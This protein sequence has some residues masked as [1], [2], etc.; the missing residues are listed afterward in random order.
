MNGFFN[1]YLVIDLDSQTWERQPLSDSDL[2]RTLGGKGLGLSLL[3]TYTRGVPNPLSEDNPVVLAV[4][5]ASDSKI[6]GS[7]RWVVLTRSPLTGFLAHSYSG[8]RQSTPMS[9]TGFDAFVIRGASEKPVWLEISTEGVTFHDAT[10]LWG[11]DTYDTQK[12]LH[13]RIGARVGAMVIGPAA[14][15]GVRFANIANDKWRHAGRGGAGAVL[16]AKKVKGITFKGNATRPHAE[17]AEILNYWK[18]MISVCKGNEAVGNYKRMGTPMMVAVMNNAEAFPARYWHDGAMD[19]WEDISADYLLSHLKVTVKACEQCFVA[20]AKVSEVLEGTYQGLVLE[21][22]EYETVMAFGGLCL[23][24]RLEDVLHLN[25]LCD[26]LGMDTITAGNLVAFAM[27]ASKMGKFPESI[28]YGNTAAAD[29]LIRQIAAREG[30]GAILSDGIVSAAKTLGLEDM[31]V[32]VKGMEPA[33]YDPR[34]L[35]GM[36]LAYGTSDRGACHLRATFYKPEL[37]GMIDKNTVDG[38]AALFIDFEDRATLFDSLVLCR[39]YRDLYTWDQLRRIIRMTTGMS[40]EK[41]D[42]VRIATHIANLSRHYNIRMGLT[43]EDDSLPVRFHEEPLAP[44]QSVLSRQDYETMRADYY[45]LRGWDDG[46]V[47]LTE[48]SEI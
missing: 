46:G 25:D 2:A 26:R 29:N 44:T 20:C 11:K 36:G 9:R 19:G 10:D 28:P 37:A 16:G 14:E 39:F 7:S 40:L 21:G 24:K 15:K 22:P 33:G 48:V 23:I 47:P 5:P 34:V 6:A 18:E 30:T 1:S 3:N 12:E 42:L 43:R 31:A 38:K 17:P 8:G 45:R 4:G 41:E 32:H 35:K 13:E 27:E